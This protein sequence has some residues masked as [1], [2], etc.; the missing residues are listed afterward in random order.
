MPLKTIAQNKDFGFKFE[1]NTFKTIEGVEAIIQRIKNKILLWTDEWFLNIEDGFDWE[2]TLSNPAEEIV[3]EDLLRAYIQSDI[4]IDIVTEISV[5]INRGLRKT[6][7]TFS[8]I[9]VDGDPI[10][11][12][13]INQAA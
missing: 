3:L 2:D 9:T 7:I 5:K 13:E 6:D 10:E 12:L 11:A 4:F 1:N 8:A